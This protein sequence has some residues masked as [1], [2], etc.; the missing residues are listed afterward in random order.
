MK[1]KSKL[2]TR[3]LSI[4]SSFPDGQINESWLCRTRISLVVTWQSC[5]QR[6]TRPDNGCAW[7]QAVS[8]WEHSASGE[9]I[10]R[11]MI[12]IHIHEYI[13]VYMPPPLQAHVPNEYVLVWHVS[14]H[15]RVETHL[16]KVI[17]VKSHSL[18]SFPSSLLYGKNFLHGWRFRRK[19]YSAT[20]KTEKRML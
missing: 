6:M 3:L 20:L 4:R 15:N 18:E 1:P 16:P 2:E 9:R 11:N 17:N 14:V 10:E 7:G 5:T 8:S 12:G 13:C 19:H